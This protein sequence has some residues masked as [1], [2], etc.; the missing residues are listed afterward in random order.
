MQSF[1]EFEGRDLF[2][3]YELVLSDGH[4]SEYAVCSENP[5]GYY[6]FRFERID[7][8]VFDL[9]AEID[10]YFEGKEP[11]TAPV[12]QFDPLDGDGLH[13]KMLNSLNVFFL[14]SH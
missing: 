6:N 1:E 7:D 11:E 2:Y 13:E 14:Q 10:S 8:E 12:F 3:Y 5:L 9:D 4:V